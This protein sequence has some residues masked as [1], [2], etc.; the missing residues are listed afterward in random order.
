MSDLSNLKT[1][2]TKEQRKCYLDHFKYKRNTQEH[3]KK[4]E[5]AVIQF[6]D[7]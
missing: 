4:L 3:I 5:E 1:T 6:S 2:Y 7:E